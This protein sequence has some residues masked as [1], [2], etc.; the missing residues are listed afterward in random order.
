MPNHYIQENVQQR[1]PH[2]EGS[3]S[4]VLLSLYRNYDVDALYDT[5]TSRQVVLA[6]YSESYGRRSVN[7][8]PG[9]TPF[10]SDK[11][12]FKSPNR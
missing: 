4:F 5:I 8:V 10:K 3:R 11:Y 12:S 9:A 2:R 7:S 6:A 1:A